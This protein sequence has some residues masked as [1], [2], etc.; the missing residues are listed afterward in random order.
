MR[1]NKS[2]YR[3]KIHK[4]RKEAEE[5]I[6]LRYSFSKSSFG[7]VLIASTDKG[8]CF[9]AFVGDKKSALAD[10]KRR[11]PDPRFEEKQDARQKKA[12]KVFTNSSRKSDTIDVHIEGTPFQHEVWSALLNIPSG[13]TATYQEI[14]QRIKKP[15]AI[16]AVGSAIGKNPVAYLVPC[17]RVIK[18]NG[19]IGGY[20]WGSD[21]KIALL[22]KEGLFF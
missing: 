2:S 19:N 13:K 16:R 22:K 9:L 10:L 20:L 6:L 17:H 11:F 14:A 18:S 15:N 4:M 7:D 12:L 3:I 8:I 5:N 1:K 21:R